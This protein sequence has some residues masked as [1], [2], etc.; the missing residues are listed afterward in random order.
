[1]GNLK[2]LAVEIQPDDHAQQ[3]FGHEVRIVMPQ[4][5]GV[6]RLFEAMRQALLHADHAVVED[7][8]RLVGKPVRLGFDQTAGL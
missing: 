4:L 5:A 3:Q 8:L 6:D 1:M 7:L 2:P